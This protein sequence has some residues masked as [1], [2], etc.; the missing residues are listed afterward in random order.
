MIHKK[1]IKTVLVPGAPWPKYEKPKPKK[2]SKQK[3][4]TEQ[5]DLRYVKHVGVMQ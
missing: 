2:H 4:S 1:I 5:F 3:R